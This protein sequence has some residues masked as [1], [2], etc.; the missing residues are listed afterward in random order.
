MVRCACKG[1][2]YGIDLHSH[3]TLQ[4]TLVI[5]P[6]QTYFMGQTW[7]TFDAKFVASKINT[8]TKYGKS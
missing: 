8:K 2:I 7:I 3:N 6:P 1:C 4:H 5:T